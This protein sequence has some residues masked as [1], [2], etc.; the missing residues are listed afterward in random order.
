M[1]AASVILAA[2][3]VCGLD[4]SVSNECS[5]ALWNRAVVRAGQASPAIDLSGFRSRVLYVAGELD[6]RAEID[7]G[8]GVWT[9]TGIKRRL[10]GVYDLRPLTAPKF[11]LV[12][13]RDATNVTAVAYLAN[14]VAASDA[15]LRKGGPWNG[16]AAKAGKPSEP[17]SV[18][19]FAQKFLSVSSDSGANIAIEFD[20]TGRGTWIPF[21]TFRSVDRLDVS[22]LRACR[23][24]AVAD[25]DC[26]ATVQLEYR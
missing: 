2:A 5:E 7:A 18:H 15:P 6:F 16:S 12:A 14:P 21:R 19:G 1:I 26:T 3:C 13:N 10:P 20:V 4:H 17:F 9:R 25:R 22:N 23:I 8:D 11:R 24:R